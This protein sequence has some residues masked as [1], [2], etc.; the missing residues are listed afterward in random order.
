MANAPAFGAAGTPLAGDSITAANVPAPA[1][2]VENNIVLVPIY[3][4]AGQTVTPPA[5]WEHA[6]SS[7]VI[8]TGGSAHQLNMLWHRASGVESGT[9]NFTVAAGLNWRFGVALRISG[10]VTAGSPFE[11]VTSAA[12]T[13][14][15]N[16]TTPSV[17]TV[18][19]GPDRLWLWLASS[20]VTN[21]S[22]PPSGFTERVDVSD[23]CALT[24]AT[25]VGGGAGAVTGT[26]ANAT[27]SAAWMAAFKPV[28]T[29]AF[30]ALM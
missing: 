11:S 23:Q 17:S 9:Y 21:T 18:A 27:A 25:R 2:V 30:F 29:D 14:N 10:C 24:V 19:A 22:T 15:A 12:K 8:V 3:V 20:F 6:P 16:G 26:F 7:P 5:G 4:E 13:T 1:G 28:N